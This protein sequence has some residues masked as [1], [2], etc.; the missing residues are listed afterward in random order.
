[1]SLRIE[2]YAM[3]G[4]CQT[5]A[6]VGNDG[7]IDWLCVP[8][9]DSG[10]CFAAM[11]G[12]EE[13]GR[14]KIAPTAPIKSVRRQYRDGTLVLETEF[15]TTDGG[16]IAL[17]DF[18]PLRDVGPDA[19]DVVRIVEGRKGTVACRMDLIVRFDYG[20]I[21]PWVKHED[22]TFRA[23]AGPDTLFCRAPIKLH[24]QRFH[25]V[26]DFVVREGERVPFVLTW[27]HTYDPEPEIRAADEMLEETESWWRNW[28]DQC[29]YQGEW[30]D[31]VLR[32]LVTLKGLTY[33]PTGGVVAA[34]TTSLPE[35]LGGVRNWDY[36]YC[37]LRDATTSLS[38]LLH[39]GYH[40]EAKAWRQ[41]LVNAVAGTPSMLQIMYG[42]AG[43]RRLTEFQL[44][45]LDGYENS[46]PVRI[47]NA[48]HQQHQLD[49]YGEVLGALHFARQRGMAESDEAWQLQVAIL[50]FLEQD[51]SKPDDGIWEMR[52]PQRHFTHSKVMA[53]VAFQCA[54]EAV[55]QFGLSG[56]LEGWRKTRDA[57]HAEVLA[58][59]FNPK[60]NA[61][62]QYYGSDEPDASLLI[63]PLVGFLPAT[64]PRMIG[65]VKLIEE[66]L[67]HDGFIRRYMPHP[68]V[69]GLPP[70]EGAFLLCTFWLADV[71]ALQ[72]RREEATE[73]FRRLLSLRNDVGLLSEEYDAEQKR[74]VGNFP[75]AFSHVGLINTAMRLSDGKPMR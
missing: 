16:R 47:G 45:W 34:A 25:T 56:D 6:L 72:G 9:F 13:N 74:L 36:R 41:W 21:V 57:I 52:G 43:E 27:S 46:K 7:S 8:R 40:D 75:Q 68:E 49:V 64:D 15:E 48:A 17:I 58:R 66:K 19:S 12:N 4:D 18:M 26:G 50:K 33:A 32:S 3:I 53:W 22:G 59:G 70:G 51:W 10:A 73:L 28:A 39:G 67:R 35:T 61:F 42:V 24:G 5:V 31:A 65:T 71:L 69:D 44:D 37:W 2:D 1:M 63:I 62:T 14:W 38:A 29:K 30:R 23:T 60:V 11:L 20:S 54:V 55:E